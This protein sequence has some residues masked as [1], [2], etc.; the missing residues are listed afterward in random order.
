MSVLEHSQRFKRFLETIPEPDP[1]DPNS[2]QEYE[3]RVL[4]V[5]DLDL[6][7]IQT[8]SGLDREQLEYLIFDLNINAINNDNY[9]K[10]FEMLDIFAFNEMNIIITEVCRI[11]RL[12]GN[13]YDDSKLNENLSL[14]NLIVNHSCICLPRGEKCDNEDEAFERRHYFCLRRPLMEVIT[15]RFGGSSLE[16]IRQMF[17]LGLVN[18]ND[19]AENNLLTAYKVQPDFVFQYLAD[20]PPTNAKNIDNYH[21]IIA[22]QN[23]PKMFPLI[24][25]LINYGVQLN[26]EE[27]E[28]VKELARRNPTERPWAEA[29][30][31]SQPQ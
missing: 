22:Y 4:N 15:K 19:L 24:R 18:L 25:T 3:N 2:M 21:R 23:L 20:H 8:I 16:R 9:A 12:S 11:G 14:K 7:E 13:N 10:I 29:Y 28:R 5:I 26:E 17:D 1:E 30:L 31:Q 6:G 27:V